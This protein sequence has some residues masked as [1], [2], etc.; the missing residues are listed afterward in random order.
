VASDSLDLFVGASGFRQ[1]DC[2][3]FPQSVKN[4]IFRQ[5]GFARRLFPFRRKPVTV[6][7]GIPVNGYKDC[8]ASGQL[9]EFGLQVLV[10]RYVE[11]QLPDCRGNAQT[12]AILSN[13]DL[14]N[15]QCLSLKN[16]QCLWWSSSKHDMAEVIIVGVDGNTLPIPLGGWQIG[17]NG[18]V[19][20][21]GPV[22][23]RGRMAFVEKA[24]SKSEAYICQHI[25]V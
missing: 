9:V 21:L 14:K 15:S 25:I 3:R 12:T 7:V 24:C 6:S 11:M 4:T 20:L 8:L 1:K 18:W 22:P 19:S 2:C 10:Q 13:I 16:S 23:Q 5:A 17:K